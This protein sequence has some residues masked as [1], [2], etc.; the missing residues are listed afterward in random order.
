MLLR[1]VQ[2]LFV[3]TFLLGLFPGVAS[4]NGSVTVNPTQA[5]PG[6][7]VTVSGT[8]WLA[9]DQILISF[10]DPAGNILP[11]GIIAADSSGAFQKVIPIPP[12]VPPGT[13]QIDGNGQGGSVS[14]LLT[15]LA[16]PTSTVAI[17][18]TPLP[19]SATVEP[20]TSVPTDVTTLLPTATR[21]FT[22]TSTPS[23]T[24]TR[25][26]TPTNTATP[27]PTPTSTATSTPT[28]TPTQTPTLPEKIVRA[29]GGADLTGFIL[30]LL[31][32]AGSLVYV[33]RR[34]H[35]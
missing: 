5:F 24:S 31:V 21:T 33:R 32:L 20:P 15:I 23:S 7:F 4:A 8:G 35:L 11:L 18:P 6:Q 25:T 17:A 14:V 16:L 30:V 10:T 22:P 12:G 3:A 13:Y 28:S 19:P 27:T 1:L 29:N 9:H 26:S 34:R 2:T